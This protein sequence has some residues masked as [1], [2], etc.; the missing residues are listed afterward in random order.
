[1]DN[2]A[3]L[4]PPVTRCSQ[5]GSYAVRPVGRGMEVKAAA[6]CSSRGAVLLPGLSRM[7][8]SVPLFSFAFVG[9]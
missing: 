9:L 5:C 2:M 3:R 7:Q 6:D 1:M 8:T 4:N